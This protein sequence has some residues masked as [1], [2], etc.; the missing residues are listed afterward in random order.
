MG[1]RVFIAAL[2]YGLTIGIVAIISFFMVVFCKAK[3]SL[4]DM[5]AGTYITYSKPGEIEDKQAFVD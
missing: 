4:H 3:R 2:M 1:L 5:M